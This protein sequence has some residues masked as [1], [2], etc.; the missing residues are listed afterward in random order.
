MWCNCRSVDSS[1]IVAPHP[2][3]D[4][5]SDLSN[6]RLTGALPSAPNGSVLLPSLSTLNLENNTLSS[7]LPATW[8]S[9]T[10]LPLLTEMRLGQNQL[11]GTLPPQW[12]SAGSFQ[13]L[14]AL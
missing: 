4:L 2:C 3:P 6:N 14:T 12:G 5:R 8:G 7:T 11:Q 1:P 9:T 10:A 13:S